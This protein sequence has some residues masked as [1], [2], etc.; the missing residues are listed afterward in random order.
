MPKKPGSF[1]YAK[2]GCKFTW[3]GGEYIT[4]SIDG[5]PLEVVN[6]WDYDNNQLAINRDQVS[7]VNACEEWLKTVNGD[8]MKNYIEAARLLKRA[9]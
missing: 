2:R 6:V 9:R 4:V 1:S 8:E 7:F 3:E 5:Q